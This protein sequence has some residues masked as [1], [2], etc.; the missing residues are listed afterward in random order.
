MTCLLSDLECCTFYNILDNLIF[1]F[2]LIICKWTSRPIANIISI[3]NLA[4]LTNQYI[5]SSWYSFL[6]YFFDYY[7]TQDIRLNPWGLF[8]LLNLVHFEF[9]SHLLLSQ[10]KFQKTKLIQF[11][12][13]KTTL[14]HIFMIVIKEWL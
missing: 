12:F 2:S 9:H 6:F 5:L 4:N 7:N 1:A 3:I 14:M 8:W 13:L 10:I 11:E